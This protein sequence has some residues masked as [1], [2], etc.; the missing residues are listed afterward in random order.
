MAKKLIGVALVLLLALGGW[1]AYYFS[2]QEVVRRQLA[3]L[4]GELSKEGKETPVQMA[5]KLRTIKEMLAES[6]QVTIADLDHVEELERDL[7]I[8][9]LIYYRQRYVAIKITFAEV[10]INIPAKGVATVQ[11]FV[12]LE[13][14]KKAGDERRAE[15]Y[16]VEIALKKGEDNWLINAVSIPDALTK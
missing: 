3:V 16:P 10:E 2:D 4:A 5:V 11:A 12:S 1:L 15:R 7:V 13:R 14:V 9:Y 8:H 6:C